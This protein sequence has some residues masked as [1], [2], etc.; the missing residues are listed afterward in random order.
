MR[1]KHP[2]ATGPLTFQ[3]T[4]DSTQLQFTTKEVEKAALSFR[5][6]S[7]PGTS[8]QR[9]EH[10]RVVLKDAPANRTVKA[11]SALSRVVNL[12]ARGEVPPTVAPFLCGAR[13]PAPKAHLKV[14]R[15]N[16][17]AE[18]IGLSCPSPDGDGG[19]GGL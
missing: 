13:L 12:M 5:K 11:I 14:G 19:E 18:G 2:P 9:P 3:R 4:S 16:T 7:A 15:L 10:L 17:G 1:K 8:G 6:S